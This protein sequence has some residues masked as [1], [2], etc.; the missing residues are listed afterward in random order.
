MHIPLDPTVS[1][2]GLCAI[3]FNTEECKDTDK[4]VYY[5]IFFYSQTGNP[6]YGHYETRC[7]NDIDHVVGDYAHIKRII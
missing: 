2:L 3:Y 5:N 6:W 4:Y 1:P 7:I